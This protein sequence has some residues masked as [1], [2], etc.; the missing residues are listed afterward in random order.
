MIGALLLALV[1]DVRPVAGQEPEPP[2][3]PLAPD[4]RPPVTATIQPRR[5]D[6]GLSVFDAFDRSDAVDTRISQAAN[7][8]L[9]QNVS[10]TGVNATLTYTQPGPDDSFT[11]AGGVGLRYYSVAPSL[12]PTNY[13][14]GLNFSKRLSRRVNVRASE[15]ASM[16]PFYT[17]GTFGPVDQ[18]VIPGPR[19]DYGVVEGLQHRLV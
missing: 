2:Q 14:G 15:V 5:L 10:F 16:S 3:D 11:A 13:Y 18:T 6:L 8:L 1:A 17:F 12:F 7:P 19:V 4:V 9:E